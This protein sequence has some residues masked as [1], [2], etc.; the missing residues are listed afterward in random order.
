MSK[1][2]K[3]TPKITVA[4]QEDDVF[5]DASAQLQ[6]NINKYMPYMLEIRKRILSIFAVFVIGASIGFAFFEPIIK[7]ILTFYALEGLNIVFTSPFQFINLAINSAVVIGTITV[8]P[9]F[10]YQLLHFLKPALKDKEYRLLV[11][12]I[13]PSII[14]FIIG[15][16][17]GN[18]IMKLMVILF[19]QQSSNFKIDNLWDIESFIKN[20]FTTSIF[21]GIF[22]Q[23]PIVVTGLIKLKI[24]KYADITKLRMPIYFILLAITMLLPPTDLLSNLLIYL[25]LVLL[26]E[27]TLLLN[28]FGIKK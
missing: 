4:P 9:F 26:F 22:F 11:A 6:A 8:F 18:W 3:K 25:P 20:I 12:A 28:R 7:I 15:F 14:L 24:V 23:F 5:D 27:L 1:R 21:L 10:I 2:K 13:P 16:I 17:F 19:S